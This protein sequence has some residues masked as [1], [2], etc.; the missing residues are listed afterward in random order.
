MTIGYKTE[1]LSNRYLFSASRKAR[2]SKFIDKSKNAAINK[3]IPIQ[4]HEGSDKKTQGTPLNGGM[5][6]LKDE[7]SYDQEKLTQE[8]REH[9]KHEE[10]LKKR[11][12]DLASNPSAYSNADVIEQLLDCLPL[13]THESLRSAIDQH[14]RKKYFAIIIVAFLLGI[15]APLVAW[16]TIEYIQNG[17]FPDALLNW[18]LT[19][20]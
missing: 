13:T 9:R 17:Q 11:V 4:P 16:H 14:Y 8:L 18:I 15:L 1:N 5:E 19:L 7:R 12:S 20:S 6:H 2:M 10:E 3:N